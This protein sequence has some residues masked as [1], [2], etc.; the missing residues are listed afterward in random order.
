MKPIVF[1]AAR[2]HRQNASRQS[3]PCERDRGGYLFAVW[4]GGRSGVSYCR[5]CAPSSRIGAAW[6]VGSSR[7]GRPVLLAEG[8]VPQLEL[9]V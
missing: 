2:P 1:E 9:R 4:G 5:R 6:R 7:F 3:K 8:E